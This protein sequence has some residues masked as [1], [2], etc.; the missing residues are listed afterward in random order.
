MAC[1][2][3]RRGRW[4]VDFRDQHGRRHWKSYRTK[5]AADDA[6]AKLH[7][8]VKD[9]TYVNPTTLPTF[10][11]VATWWLEGKR[12]HPASTV[13]YWQGHIERHFLPTFGALRV[14]KV[15]PRLI[16]TFRNE[17]R[18]GTET[19]GKLARGT[20]NQLLQTLSAIL[21]YAVG[22]G[23]L[24]HNPTTRVKRVRVD[25]RPGVKSAVAVD[26]KEVLTAAQAG[27]LID[28]ADVGLYQTYIA[29]SLM[30][31][32]RSGELLALAWEHIALDAPVPTL[33]VE[34]SLSWKKVPHSG[35]GTSEPVFGPPKSD[36]SYRTLELAPETITTLKAWKLRSRFKADSDLV[37]SNSLGKPLHRAF[38]HKGLHLALDRCPGLPRVDL[39]GMRH[40]FASILIGQLGKSASEVAHLLGHKNADITLKVYTHWFPGESSATTMGDLATLIRRPG[41]SKVVATARVAGAN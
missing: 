14:D 16:E 25:R 24:A 15:T 36:S 33:R 22:H 40:S 30:T 37:F 26:P 39:H 13:G 4:V 21:D 17:R 5:K 12:D 9:H 28:A 2:R 31:G 8:E 34:R 3:K 6:A 20:T 10:A 19:V 27:Q 7:N 41:G 1:V 38:L 23:Y 29:T 18:D 32:C 35:Y 11:E